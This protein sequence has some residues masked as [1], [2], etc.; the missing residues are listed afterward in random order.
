MALDTSNNSQLIRSN[1]WTN[2]IKDVLQEDLMLDT[3]VRWITDF[4]DGTTLNIP[5]FS[6]M[7]VRNYSE[8]SQIQLDNPVTGNFTL[9]IDKYYQAGFRITDKFKD[10]SFY[11]SQ[12]EANFVSKV[13]RAVL[14]QKES[15][16]AHLQSGQTAS[17]PN[18]INGVDHRYIA[19][20]SNGVFTV[21]DIQK[22]KYAHD[23][24]KVSRTGR[25][26]YLDPGVTYRL[27]QIDN[28][29]RQDV[30]GSNTRLQEGMSGMTNV[31]RYAGYEMFE[32]LFL[33]TA[34]AETIVATAP[35]SGSKSC[36]AGIANMFLGE[37]AFIGAMRAA[38]DINTWYDNP[39]RSECHHLTIRY[40]LKLFRPESLV[41]VIND[42]A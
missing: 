4:P 24:A 5:T 36:T 39:T 18:V 42:A 38:P 33:D 30:F 31:G 20:G 16:I 8:G 19:T 26:A 23:K 35:N 15:D 12:A 11:V 40:G 37:D 25:R 21:A 14:E 2:E 29:I 10:D 27:Q 28:V 34:L 3:C 41:V 22:A 7:T 1:L 6:E 9:T 13:T 17:D 32:S